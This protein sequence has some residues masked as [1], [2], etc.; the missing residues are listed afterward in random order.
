MHHAS[1]CLKLNITLHVYQVLFCNFYSVVLST[2]ISA[3]NPFPYMHQN[4]RK[5]KQNSLRQLAPNYIILDQQ[6]LLPRVS[7]DIYSQAGDE[8]ES[9]HVSTLPFAKKAAALE[10][11]LER[12]ELVP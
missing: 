11:K 3:A 9:E 2:V 6:W 12:A 10:E 1:G 8:G 4:R 5:K 7:S